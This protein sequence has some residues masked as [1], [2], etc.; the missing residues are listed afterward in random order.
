MTL[1]IERYET[2][3]SWWRLRSSSHRYTVGSS[4][5]RKAWGDLARESDE[6]E[7]TCVRNLVRMS[8]QHEAWLGS[9]AKREV[10]TIQDLGVV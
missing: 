8:G 9:S 3:T 4:P 5:W 1:Y 10:R 2:G 7:E 6:H